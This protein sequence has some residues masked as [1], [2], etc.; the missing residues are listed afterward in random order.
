[1]TA[2]RL[3]CGPERDVIHADIQLTALNGGMERTL[4]ESAPNICSPSGGAWPHG[5]ARCDL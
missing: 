4:A 2:Q 1:M 5:Y 3:R